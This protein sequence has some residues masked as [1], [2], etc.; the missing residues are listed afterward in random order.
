MLTTGK[1]L[2]LF[3]V[4]NSVGTA[5]GAYLEFR[6]AVLNSGF[7]PGETNSPL[8]AAIRIAS[9]TSA[10][11]ILIAYLSPTLPPGHAL[12]TVGVN[13]D[14]DEGETHT[15]I[16]RTQIYHSHS[17]RWNFPEGFSSEHLQAATEQ[18]ERLKELGPVLVAPGERRPVFAVTNKLGEVFR[19]FFELIGPRSA[20]QP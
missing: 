8:R 5:L 16:G 15:S 17:C 19:G 9:A 11:G 4:W 1:P 20:N 12:L 7:N 13:P 10:P 2:P 18:L 3:Y 14:G 6:P